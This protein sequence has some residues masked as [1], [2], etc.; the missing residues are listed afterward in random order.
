[1]QA[2]QIIYHRHM[3]Q[4]VWDAL[5]QRSRETRRKIHLRCPQCHAEIYPTRNAAPQGTGFPRHSFDTTPLRCL[6]CHAPVEIYQHRELTSNADRR[7]IYIHVSGQHRALLTLDLQCLSCEQ[8]L[9]ADET[10]TNTCGIQTY[11]VL[12]H[13]DGKLYIKRLGIRSDALFPREP[14]EIDTRN[15]PDT[16]SLTTANDTPDNQPVN[17]PPNQNA[18]QPHAF[19]SQIPLPPNAHKDFAGQVV[20][21]LKDAPDNTATTA[22]MITAIECT[23]EGFNKA[24]KKLLKHGQIR[25]VKRGVY[26]LINHT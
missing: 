4:R 12:E 9:Q 23:P 3:P 25:K 15:F 14:T 13:D 26:E 20:A 22:E 16:D 17:L 21:F 5:K 19:D 8:P 7:V 10:C 18:S 1:M 11:L 6:S 24:R 2:E